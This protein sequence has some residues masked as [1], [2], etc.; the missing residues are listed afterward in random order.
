ME[1]EWGVRENKNLRLSK[2]LILS[3]IKIK[4]FDVLLYFI[5]RYF[6]DLKEGGRKFFWSVRKLNN[7][8]RVKISFVV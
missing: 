1:K 5:E 7:R 8:E 2:I 6:W 4:N 3:D